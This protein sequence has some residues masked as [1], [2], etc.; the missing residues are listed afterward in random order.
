MC[1]IYVKAIRRLDTNIHKFN[2]VRVFKSL[3]LCS[4]RV[5]GCEQDVRGIWYVDQ[6]QRTSKIHK[7]RHKS[8]LL[9]LSELRTNLSVC[10]SGKTS[11]GYAESLR[12][13]R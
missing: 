12:D 11:W 5:T 2:I 3:A 7:R 9:G 1:K 4:I 6:K 10:A 13:E 8:G